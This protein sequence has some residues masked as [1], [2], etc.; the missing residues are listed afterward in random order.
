V[1]QAFQNVAVL[2]PDVDA[3]FENIGNIYPQ[4]GK[5]K[6]SIPYCHKALQIEPDFTTYTNLGTS[7]FFLKQHSQAVDM[8]QKAVS[9][10]P[11]DAGLILNLADAYRGLG[12]QDRARSAYQQTI[13]MGFK[14]LERTPQDADFMT[15]IALAYANVG[16]ATQALSFIRQ[17]RGSEE[18][19]NYV[20][21]EAEIDAILGHTSNALSSLR[22]AF[23]KHC[24]AQFA[25]GDEDLKNL[26]ATSE[27]AALI[28]Q[29]SGS[30]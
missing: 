28:K 7:F 13:T 30:K 12:Q 16:N 24:P 1:L 25:V 18:N 5:Y 19:V 6:E 22:Q 10:N 29:Y 14:Q 9:L 15:S 20:Y 26:N 21:A 4:E 3:G 27:F 17:A 2:E 11:N 23:E 8:F